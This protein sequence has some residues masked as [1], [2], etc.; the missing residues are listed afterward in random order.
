MDEETGTLQRF[1]EHLAGPIPPDGADAT[2][3]VV[4]LESDCDAF[5]FIVVKG[6]LSEAGDAVPAVRRR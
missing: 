1:T 3:L 6:C 5:G 4:R 2:L